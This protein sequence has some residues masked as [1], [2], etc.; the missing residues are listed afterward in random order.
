[1]IPYFE[2]H[3]LSL[4]PIVLQTWGLF[5]AAGFVLGGWLA[6]KRASSRGL[7]PKVVWDMVFW[8]F[9]AAFIGARLFQILLEWNFYLANPWDAI[10]PRKP[11]YAIMG[12]FLRP[13]MEPTAKSR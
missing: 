1:M 9:I 13:G 4:G 5:V 11:G 3:T 7:D 10:D 6:A 8:I 2:S 12:G